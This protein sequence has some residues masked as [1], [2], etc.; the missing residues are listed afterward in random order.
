M[1]RRPCGPGSRVGRFRALQTAAVRPF[2]PGRSASLKQGRSGA[3][4]GWRAALVPAAPPF[5]VAAPGGQWRPL[6]QALEGP[7]PSASATRRLVF[8]I[9]LAPVAGQEAVL[10]RGSSWSSRATLAHDS[11][12]PAVPQGQN[13]RARGGE[14][15]RAPAR[16]AAEQVPIGKRRGGALVLFHGCFRRPDQ[17]PGHLFNGVGSERKLPR[18]LRGSP[19]RVPERIGEGP[20]ARAGGGPGPP[21]AFGPLAGGFGGGPPLGPLGAA[22]LGRT[23]WGSPR[24]FAAASSTN[25]A[26][27]D[28]QGLVGWKPLE[29]A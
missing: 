8:Q 6:R 11:L 26:V 20:Q 10:A 1:A 3:T 18:R 14:Q 12:R 13:R 23:A 21:R 25:R 7:P 24:D 22:R 19:L 4:S 29:A 16:A 15:H 17:I 5:P 9:G 27:G 2:S 28:G